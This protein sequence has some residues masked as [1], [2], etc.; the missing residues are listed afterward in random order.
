LTEFSKQQHVTTGKQLHN[1]INFL[2]L[3]IHRRE[4]EFQFAVYRRR[5]QTGTI[6]PNDECDPYEHKTVNIKQIKHIPGI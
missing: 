5:T 6:I 2:D 1:S 3:W 4:K